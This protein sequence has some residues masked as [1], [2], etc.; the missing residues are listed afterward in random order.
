[1]E[2]LLWVSVFV[3][4]C[5][6][7]I[8][9]VFEG[10]WG[11]ILNLICKNDH[12]IFLF[13]VLNALI[14]TRDSI[15]CQRIKVCILLLTALAHVH[16]IV[17]L[18]LIFLRFDRKILLF[19]FVTVLYLRGQISVRIPFMVVMLL[20]NHLLCIILHINLFEMFWF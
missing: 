1:M 4:N 10:N 18:N 6:V 9:M 11:W 20:L 12:F 13:R 16:S 8:K 3:N 15:Y 2:N 19:C 7:E 17:I 14:S 5:L